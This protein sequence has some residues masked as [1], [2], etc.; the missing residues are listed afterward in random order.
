MDGS[1]N[2]TV[3]TPVVAFALPS[4]HMSLLVLAAT[5]ACDTSKDVAASPSEPPARRTESVR[6]PPAGT[7]TTNP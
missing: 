6:T 7:S 5:L 3:C 1:E 2:E 4:A